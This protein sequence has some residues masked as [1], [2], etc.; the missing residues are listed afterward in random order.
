[1][2]IDRNMPQEKAK[3]AAGLKA[4]EF[5]QDGMVIGLGT[6][7]TAYFFIKHLIQRCQQGLKI[8]AVATSAASEKL[9]REGKIPMVDINHITSLDLTVDGADQIDSK[10]RLIKGAGGALMREKIIATMSQ[11]MVVIADESKCVEKLGKCLL[12][13]EVIPFGVEAI[14]QQITGLG[15]KGTWRT[16]Q[17]GTF[18][19][20]DN[21]NRIFDISLPS[22]L[23]DPEQLHEELTVIPGVLATGFF[24]NLATYIVIGKDDGSVGVKT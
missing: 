7:S 1:M 9:A 23:N 20:T 18:Y 16:K 6:G 21:Q 3:D 19:L 10:K 17:D 15:Y 2:D 8:K 24:F 4:L 14:K 12:P 22:P 11:T 13:I 5:V